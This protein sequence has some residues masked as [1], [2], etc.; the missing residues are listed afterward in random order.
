MI[1]VNIVLMPNLFPKELRPSEKLFPFIRAYESLHDGDLSQL[2]LQPKLDPVG[3]WTEGW[4]H[5]MTRNGRKMTVKDYPTLE[6]ILP[7][8]KIKTREDADA[9]L[10][11]DVEAAAV[12]VRKHLKI[13]VRQYEFDAL[14]DHYYNCGLSETLYRLINSRADKSKI[15]DWI[16]TRY[17]SAN[18]VVLK[19]LKYRRNDDYEIYAGINYE[20]EYKLSV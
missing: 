1:P 15:K 4:G 10:R 6:S 19:G 3:Y 18:G 7:F 2:G 11:I 16:T 20:R 8:S 14:V 17:I 5:L 12:E 9:F 13:K